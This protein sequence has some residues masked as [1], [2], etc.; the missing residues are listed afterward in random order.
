MDFGV[1]CECGQCLPATEKDA[2]TTLTCSCGRRVVVPAEEELQPGRV[3]LS[4]ATL[5][6]R[7]QR[8]IAAGELPSSTAC[9]GCGEEKMTDVVSVDLVCERYRAR[10]S[11]GFRFLVFPWFVVWWN[12]PRRQEIHGRDTDIRVPVCLCPECS[13]RLRG[14]RRWAYLALAF[15][16]VDVILPLIYYNPLIGVS[17]LAV[18]LAS[19]F[20]HRRW[21]LER[22][23]K[24]FKGF[25]RKAPLYRQ[26]LDRYP[27]ASAELS[28]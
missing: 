11:G 7:I 6:R 23:Q 13:Q 17:T 19:F 28:G 4:A 5:E 24:V 2:S 27:H 16:A 26:L 8:L 1:C 9:I 14:P 12:E 20:L 21:A 10:T 15:V 3:F 25:L 18:V 22:R